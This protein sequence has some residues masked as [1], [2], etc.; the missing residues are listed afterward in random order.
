LSNLDEIIND[1]ISIIEID[2]SREYND[3]TENTV[4]NELLSI[5]SEEQGKGVYN[6]FFEEKFR[7]IAEYAQFIAEKMSETSPEETNLKHSFKQYFI[8]STKQNSVKKQ[9]E[10]EN[11]EELIKFIIDLKIIINIMIDIIIN[12]KYKENKQVDEKLYYYDFLNLLLTNAGNDTYRDYIIIPK[13]NYRF[14]FYL[15]KSKIKIYDLDTTIT[16]FYR[17]SQAN[18]SNIHLYLTYDASVICDNRLIYTNIISSEVINYKYLLNNCEFITQVFKNTNEIKDGLSMFFEDPIIKK[19]IL[20]CEKTSNHIHISFNK[21]NEIIKPNINIILAIIC[22]CYYYQDKIFELFLKTRS[23]NYYCKKIDFNNARDFNI[24]SDYDINLE[25]FFT[26]FYTSN[27]RENRYYWLNLVNLY[28]IDNITTKRPPTIEFRIK[29]GSSDAEELEKVC[30]LYKNIINFGISL[31]TY[32]PT[33]QQAT[34]ISFKEAIDE[35]ISKDPNIFNNIILKDIDNYFIDHKSNYVKGLNKL[36]QLLKDSCDKK[37]GGR[38]QLEQAFKQSSDI[39][40]HSLS[41]KVKTLQITK[42]NNL[43]TYIEK[44]ETKPIYKRNS[45]GYQF[46]GYGLD[47]NII[48]TLKTKLNNNDSD[49]IYNNYLKLNNIFS[50]I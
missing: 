27:I 40:N 1:L 13:F 24:I 48:S 38:L 15:T 41:A 12:K 17:Q 9:Q 19:S 47:N 26:I 20:N 29:H 4:Y 34:I 28:K 49:D 18:N 35:Y 6:D 8:R 22:I 31:T 37:S 25:N 39:K 33:S 32:I 10:P 2:K 45:F 46:I 7:L 16:D 21:N 42:I 3:L 30:I 11:I 23:N 36:N 44:L 5:Y 43:D 50:E 14:N